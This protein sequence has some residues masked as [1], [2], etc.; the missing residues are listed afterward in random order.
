M[1]RPQGNGARQGRADGRHGVSV[2]DVLILKLRDDEPGARA[3]RR[4]S[5]TLCVRSLRNCSHHF[6]WSPQLIGRQTHQ[7]A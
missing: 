1:G 5:F 6:Y 3:E 2:G 4:A 7:P